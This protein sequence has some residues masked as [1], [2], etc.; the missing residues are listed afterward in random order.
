MMIKKEVKM[1]GEKEGRTIP[2]Q[3]AVNAKE[4]QLINDLNR[5]PC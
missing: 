2:L 3:V 4:E 1:N 5:Q